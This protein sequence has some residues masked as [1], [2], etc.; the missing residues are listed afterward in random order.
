VENFKVGSEAG[1]PLP[2]TTRLRVNLRVVHIVDKK[3]IKYL[4][5]QWLLEYV[6][7]K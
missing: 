4:F 3:T 6:K 2:I 7:K 5:V 1:L